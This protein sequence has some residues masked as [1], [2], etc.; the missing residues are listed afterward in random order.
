VRYR[1]NAGLSAA[2]PA[3]EN[4]LLH[5]SHGITQ[6][7][8]GAAIPLTVIPHIFA[9]TPLQAGEKI[10]LCTDGLTDTLDDGEIESVLRLS[11]LEG[12]HQRICA[13]LKATI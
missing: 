7:L 8:G 12:E 6:A 9:G 13:S 5:Q 1:R 2:A 10:L 3:R 4:M 11:A